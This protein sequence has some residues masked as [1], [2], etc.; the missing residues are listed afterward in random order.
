VRGHGFEVKLE[1]IETKGVVL[2]HQAKVID[3]KTRGCR[4]LEQAP[5]DIVI[6]VL[7][8]VRLLVS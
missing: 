7:A 1:C 3:Y 6:D 8:K 2:C 5:D 4:F